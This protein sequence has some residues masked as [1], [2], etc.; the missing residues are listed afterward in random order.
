[1]KPFLSLCLIVKNEELVLKRCLDS[2]HNIVD[3]IIVVDTGSTDRTKEIAQNYVSHVYNF[4]WTNSFSDAR[5][6]AQSKASGKWI[7]VLDADEYVDGDNLKNA[8]EE[9]KKI[10]Q[11]IDAFEVNI[12]NFTGENAERIVQHKSIRIYKNNPSI[13]FFRTIHEQLKKENGDL[14]VGSSNLILYHSGY[15]KN[16]VKEKNKGERNKDLIEKQSSLAARTAFDYFNL[17]N[18]YFSAGEV[19]KALES[20]V[21][22]HKKQ[23]NIQI[24]WVPFCIVLTVNCLIALERYKEALDMIYKKGKNFTHS[25]DFKCLKA[26]VYMLQHRYD[27]AIEE[28]EDLLNNKDYYSKTITSIDFSEFHP[29]QYLGKIYFEQKEFNKA[30]YHYVKAL[31]INTKSREILYKVIE[32]M[33]KSVSVEEI[34]QFIEDKMWIKDHQDIINMIWVSTKLN[35]AFLAQK[36]LEKLKDETTVKKSIEI[37]IGQL[38]GNYSLLSDFIKVETI[39]N[40]DGVL[41][42]GFIDLYDLTIY[43]LEA[44]KDFL[45]TLYNLVPDKEAKIFFELLAKDS[46]SSKPNEKLYIA[47]LERCIHLQRYELFEKLLLKKNN[48]DTSINLGIGNLLYQYEFTDL[49]I[50]LYNECDVNQLDSEAYLNIIVGF[51][52]CE[53]LED[54]IEY[55]L[56]ALEKEQYD[57]RFFKYAVEIMNKKEFEVE[58]KSL[59]VNLAL[60]H[61]PDCK[62][63]KS[64]QS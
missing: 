50:D 46:I 54:A 12:Y 17:G 8:I 43:A 13:H 19:N 1:M 42:T 2:V 32:I 27:E 41:K 56:L 22:A 45:V 52:Q 4:E 23:P 9:L 40:L 10:K 37:K 44:N 5:N 61:F 34:Y 31:N 15:L 16:T 35:Q 6:F 57:F 63:L 24:T 48:F 3:E 28:F 18:E 33:L 59:I 11:T 47:L 38:I 55:I 26:N 62:W 14:L 25:P 39:T 29:H 53:Y 30:I 58:K 51:M 49:A 36:Y 20:Y 21:T 64:M 60:H 7:L